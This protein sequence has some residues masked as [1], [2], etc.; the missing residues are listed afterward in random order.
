MKIPFFVRNDQLDFFFCIFRTLTTLNFA[1][2]LLKCTG[3]STFWKVSFQ[4]HSFIIYLS[5]ICSVLKKNYLE[6]VK[7]R[8]K[9]NQA[10]LYVGEGLKKDPS[11]FLTH[12]LGLLA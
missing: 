5:T 10:G 8:R 2:Y 9:K 3:P 11:K 6:F 4:T 1:L 7:G 12:S